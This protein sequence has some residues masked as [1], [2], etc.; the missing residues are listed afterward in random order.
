M[1]MAGAFIE[2]NYT[3]Y[4]KSFPAL[5]SYE[6]VIVHPPLTPPVN[7]E[8]FRDSPLA[9]EGRDEGLIRILIYRRQ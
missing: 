7:P 5:S 3:L 6:S 2:N 4:R 1:K 9:G 8:S